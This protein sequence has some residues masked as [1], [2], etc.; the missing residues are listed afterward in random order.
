[1]SYVYDAGEKYPVYY[2]DFYNGSTLVDSVSSSEIIDLQVTRNLISEKPTVGQANS[3]E[4]QATFFKPSFSIPR[5]AGVNVRIVLNS[6]TYSAGWFFI[7]T[8]SENPT[9][10]T[11]T[12][13]CYDAMLM[14]EQL[15]PTSG[16]DMTVVSAIATQIGVSVDASVTA[17]IV[18]SY[19]IT[20]DVANNS[21][22]DVLKTIG[23]AYGGSFFVTRDGLLGFAGLAIP[24]ETFYL[25]DQDGDPILFGGDRIIV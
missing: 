17:T 1:M 11:L 10:N 2:L 6:S 3:G 25:V 13:H 9:D 14:A 18:N 16:V 19:T 20:S 8:R 12:I 15:C 4:L 5:M 7:D 21:S 24:A 22:R 23:A